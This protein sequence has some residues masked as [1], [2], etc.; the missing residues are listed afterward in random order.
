MGVY[1]SYCNLD[2]LEYFSIGVCGG[3]ISYRGIGSGLSARLLA[4]LF[5]AP[6]IRWERRLDWAGDRLVVLGD[7]GPVPT[8]LGLPDAFLRYESAGE[9]LQAEFRD[10][11]REA[12]KEMLQLDPEELKS[13]ATA[14][15]SVFE[16]LGTMANGGDATVEI[17]LRKSFGTDWRR[18]YARRV[19]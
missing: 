11:S 7:D 18:E 8:G 4:Y 14:H 2:K 10:V 17:W 13:A 3:S 9:L 5:V 19:R 12:L 1:Y 6:P 15:P 16:T